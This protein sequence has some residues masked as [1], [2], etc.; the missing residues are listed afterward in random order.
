MERD[1]GSQK[2]GTE[3][4]SWPQD[5]PQERPEEHGPQDR[6][7]ERAEE[8]GQEAQALAA[9]PPLVG[10]IDEEESRL[11]AG[12]FRQREYLAVDS[13]TIFSISWSYCMPA[14]LAARA[15]SLPASR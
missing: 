13:S 10:G 7:Q 14:S 4:G 2:E 15:N 12:F 6:P 11:V 3:K 5:G 9:L 8:L 1:D